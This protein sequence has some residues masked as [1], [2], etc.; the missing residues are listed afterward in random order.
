[1]NFAAGL[2][3]LL[4]V[5][6]SAFIDK[7]PEDSPVVESRA[8]YNLAGRTPLPEA[9]VELLHAH[10]D[11]IRPGIDTDRIAASGFEPAIV[12]AEA[13]R[14]AEAVRSERIP[15]AVLYVDSLTGD[16]MP[17]AI[18]NRIVDPEARPTEWSTLYELGELTGPVATTLL[19]LRAIERGDLAL[20]DRVGDRVP[21]LVGT[22]VGGIAVEHL[23][24]HSSGLP[25]RLPLPRRATPEQAIEAL[26]A[27]ALE[28]K[29]GDQPRPNGLNFLV[30]GLVLESVHDGEPIQSAARSRVLEPAG[31]VNTT[32][33]L[34]VT[35]RERTAPGPFCGWLGRMAWGE[36]CN[37][38]AHA[39]GER[40]GNAGLV[41]NADDIGLFLRV[42]A[43]KAAAGI[44]D[45]L[46]TET[47]HLSMMPDESSA[48]GREMGL[49]WMVN[50]FGEGSIGWDAPDGSSFWLHPESGLFVVLL[51]NGEHP[52][53]SHAKAADRIRRQVLISLQR[54]VPEARPQAMLP[55]P[56]PW[57]NCLARR[58]PWADGPAIAS[59][60][61]P[62]AA[63]MLD[64]G[65]SCDA[66]ATECFSSQCF[67]PGSLLQPRIEIPFGG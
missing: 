14:L 15:G 3:A 56:S 13:L 4:A 22:E 61:A 52:D 23:L 66:R 7:K 39:L 1:M 24:R 44:D 63:K 31:M 59:A 54:C 65:V 17:I 42:V 21:E 53:R 46:S 16:N 38:A 27:L 8:D 26:E 43:A 58:G 45:S 28:S 11:R 30:L 60:S 55:A 50:G 36:S 40:A 34:P 47:L 5:L 19:A 57:G 2:A 6:A 33:D 25:A 29:P 67:H 32:R 51:I 49:G 62:A 9:Q 48:G 41:S 64:N 12:V 10:S 20:A 35:W 18:G 37:P